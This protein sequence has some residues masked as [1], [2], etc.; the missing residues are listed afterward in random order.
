MQCGA[1]ACMLCMLRACK[2]G[3]VQWWDGLRVCSGA[4]AAACCSAARPACIVCK[5]CVSAR[6]LGVSPDC[7]RNSM[8]DGRTCSHYL[9]R[10]LS[11]RPVDPGLWL[12]HHRQARSL[13]PHTGRPRALPN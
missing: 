11:V 2:R 5:V 10:H 9:H 1:A 13:Q 8:P 7:P 4:C 12:R 3:E 6:D